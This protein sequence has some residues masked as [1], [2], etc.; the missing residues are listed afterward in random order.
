MC[1]YQSCAT[2]LSGKDGD[3][4]AS[5]RHGADVSTGDTM[6]RQFST[7]CRTWCRHERWL[8][9]VGEEEH[10]PAQAGSAYCNAMDEQK[11]EGM[12]GSRLHV[13]WEKGLCTPGSSLTQ[14][15]PPQL[16]QNNTTSLGSNRKHH[17]S[18]RVRRGNCGLKIL[19]NRW[20]RVH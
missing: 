1:S 20:R 9:R 19:T 12:H 2:L 15:S 18:R 11:E 14:A 5:R 7:N 3:V 10:A 8:V 17:M 6:A 16:N 13:T 4:C